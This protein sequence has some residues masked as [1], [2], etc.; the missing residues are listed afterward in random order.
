MI[1]DE[2]AGAADLTNGDAFR[3]WLWICK[4]SHHSRDVMGVGVREAYLS[5]TEN[6]KAAAFTFHR[7]DDTR[8]RVILQCREKAND[9]DVEIYY[10]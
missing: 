2:E 6:A 3:W 4:L 10:L 9:G 7:T 1:P 8:C 5:M